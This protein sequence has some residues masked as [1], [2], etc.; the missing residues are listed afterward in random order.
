MKKSKSGGFHGI[1]Q[2]H[3]KSPPPGVGAAGLFLHGVV[4]NAR[5]GPGDGLVP[6]CKQAHRVAAAAGHRAGTPD[7]GAARGPAPAGHRAGGALPRTAAHRAGTPGGAQHGASR[8]P[9]GGRQEGN[10]R[11]RHAR[12]HHPLGARGRGAERGAAAA[13]GCATVRSARHP[14]AAGA[15][16]AGTL[17]AIRLLVQ[18]PRRA[19]GLHHHSG[20]ADRPDR[21]TRGQAQ[22][23]DC[24]NHGALGAQQ[25]AGS[26]SQTALCLPLR[27]HHQPRAFHRHRVGESF[28][29]QRQCDWAISSSR[30]VTS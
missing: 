14:D 3:N 28:Q 24:G 12:C 13:R 5:A 2:D 16:C 8:K 21:C 11:E 6:E 27:Q 20:L 9:A 1:P 4:G 25:P 19:G 29:R 22:H 17:A 30:P 26:G 10:R 18:Q 15:L 23:P 7:R